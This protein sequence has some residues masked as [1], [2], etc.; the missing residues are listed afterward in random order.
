LCAGSIVSG[1]SVD[2]SII[3]PDV[4]IGAGAEVTDSILFP[5]VRIGAGARVHRSVL[6]K[7][8]AVPPGVVVGLDP[9]RDAARFVLSDR[10]VVV[11]DKDRLVTP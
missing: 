10:G 4:R 8:V 7:N 6:D 3:G 5:G 2:G 11:V 9:A 1:G